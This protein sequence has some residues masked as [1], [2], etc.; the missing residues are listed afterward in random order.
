MT[1]PTVFSKIDERIEKINEVFRY[2]AG[3]ALVLVVI[4]VIATVLCNKIF[5]ISFPLPVD[6][7]GLLFMFVICFGFADSIFHDG[8]VRINI[9]TV[10]FKGNAIKVTEI[11]V[12]IVALAFYVIFI[13]YGWRSAVGM[14]ESGQ[15]M[16]SIRIKLYP[17]YIAM[18][19]G[20]IWT[21]VIV[22]YMLVREFFRTYPKAKA[23]EA[24][25][26]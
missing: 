10:N 19:V 11:V 8:L 9:M 17:F 3:A 16:A 12:L 25:E 18:E 20:F 24:D 6:F 22:A 14:V 1:Q 21:T 7:S 15:M 5:K 2:I 23:K 26:E 13:I 4:Q